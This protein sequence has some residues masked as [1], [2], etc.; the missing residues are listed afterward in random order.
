MCLLSLHIDIGTRC[1][2]NMKTCSVYHWNQNRNKVENKCSHYSRGIYLS[3]YLTIK[4]CFFVCLKD[5]TCLRMA[6]PAYCF[7]IFE[8]IF[9]VLFCLLIQKLILG[10]ET[11]WQSMRKFLWAVWSVSIFLDMNKEEKFLFWKLYIGMV[12]IFYTFSLDLKT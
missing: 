12:W 1:I 6:I 2:P 8:S 7:S 10:C 9:G 11:I 5:K 4:L 3:V